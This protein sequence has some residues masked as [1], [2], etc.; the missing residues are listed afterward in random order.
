MRITPTLIIC[1]IAAVITASLL[2]W[3]ADRPSVA[4]TSTDAG[5]RYLVDPPA[6]SPEI[7]IEGFAFSNLTAAPGQQLTVRNADGA[8]HTLTA[9]GGAFDTGNLAG[10]AQTSLNA[11]ARPGTYAY[12]CLIHPSMTGELVVG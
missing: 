6:T 4:A 9:V 5:G 10:G 8:A 11:P 1:M 12:F 7:V 2:A 3:P